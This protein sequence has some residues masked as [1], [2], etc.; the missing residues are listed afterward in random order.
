MT[1]KKC[2]FLMPYLLNRLQMSKVGMYICCLLTYLT[3][4]Q[5]PSIQILKNDYHPGFV[6]VW[7]FVKIPIFCYCEHFFNAVNFAVVFS[8]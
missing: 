3:S 2:H 4:F 5:K 1:Y 6:P 7:P 8:Y